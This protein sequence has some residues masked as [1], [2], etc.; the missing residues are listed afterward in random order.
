MEEQLMKFA[1]T[2]SF[3]IECQTKN[4][5]NPAYSPYLTPRN[6]FLPPKLKFSCRPNQ[7][8][9]MESKCQ[10]RKKALAFN[11]DYFENDIISMNN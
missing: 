8:V 1:R 5:K 9:L 2:A 4:A 6:Y 7:N 3:V 10:D 11:G